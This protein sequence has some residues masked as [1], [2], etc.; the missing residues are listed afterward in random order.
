[1]QWQGNEEKNNFGSR[2]ST[3]TSVHLCIILQKEASGIREAAWRKKYEGRGR[4]EA[5]V[6]PPVLLLS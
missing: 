4:S 1:M 6:S 5:E 3:V 2:R